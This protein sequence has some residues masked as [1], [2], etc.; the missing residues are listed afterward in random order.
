MKRKHAEALEFLPAA[1]ELQETPPSLE[2]G[3]NLSGGQRQRLAIARALVT[4][5][6]ILIFDEATSALD[7]ESERLIQENMRSI[8]HKRTVFIIAHRAIALSFTPRNMRR[9]TSVSS[10]CTT[11]TRPLGAILP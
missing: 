6:R 11:L 4:N 7:Y 9:T 1:L 2:H 10:G 5:P 3:S 8:C